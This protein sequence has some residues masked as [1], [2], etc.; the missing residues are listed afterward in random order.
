MRF[1]L[2]LFLYI[3]N[4]FAVVDVAT[5][6]FEENPEGFSGSLYGSLEKKR[7]S[8]D[9][10]ELALGGRIQYDTKETVTWLQGEIEKDE[11]RG[12]KTDDNSF[13]HLR[14]IH[15]LYSPEW[16]LE[17]YVQEKQDAFKDLDSRFVYG[18]GGRYR[19]INSKELGKL[20]LGLSLM[21]E[22]IDYTDEAVNPNEHNYRLGS[23]FSYKAR[24]HRNIELSSILYYQP[25]INHASDYR[26]S[27]QLEFTIH[28]TKVIDL[29]YLFQFDYDAQPA[30]GIPNNDTRQ[31]LSFIYR[32]G[33]DDPFSRY[34]SRFLQSAEDLEDI[35]STAIV[36]VEV[37]TP[38]DEI[39]NSKDTLA[40]KWIRKNEVFN[41]ELEGKGSYLYDQ[42]LYHQKFEWKLISTDTQEGAQVAKDQ[43]TKV[44]VIR[45]LDEEGRIGRIE[46][47]LWHGNKLVGLYNKQVKVFRR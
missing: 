5:I 6:D 8:T 47:Y 41:F 27:S 7:G 28:L 1:F 42:G 12:Q 46:N 3:I 32:F 19:I 34:A 40:G 21:D 4:V 24:L 16:A 37:Q 2:F 11:S 14:H 44:V 13:I 30:V 9:K 25:V 23:Y 36:A 10:D 17:A 26:L 38:I 43:S 15:Q 22:R 33:K 18:A 20:F 35:N 45:Y 31:R 29:S 39:K